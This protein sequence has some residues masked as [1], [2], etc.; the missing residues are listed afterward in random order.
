MDYIQLF[1]DGERLTLNPLNYVATFAIPA[2][3]LALLVAHPKVP[4][5]IKQLVAIPLLIANIIYPVLFTSEPILDIIGSA[6]NFTVN[7][8]FLEIVYIG[9]WLQDRPV[10]TSIYSLWVDFWSCIRVFP[11]PAKETT[12]DV[13]KGEIKVYTKDKKFYHILPPL[14]LCTVTM[15]IM[16]A[17]LGSFT[18]QDIMALRQEQPVFYSIFFLLAGLFM[19]AAFNAAGYGLHLFYCIFVEGGSYSSE[20]YHI[21]MNHPL[22]AS[23]LDD[24]WSH[25]WHQLFKTTWLAFP[26][27]P[28]RLVTQRLLAKHT[29]NYV[30]IS[31]FLAMISVFAISGLMHEYMILCNVGWPVFHNIFAGHQIIFFTIHGI[32]TVFER[33]VQT[34]AK[35]VLPSS[36]Y[37]SVAVRVL[38]H[39]WVLTFGAAFF[40]YFMEGFAHWGIHSTQP[41]QFTRPMVYDFVKSHP[42]IQQWFGSNY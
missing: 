40:S 1:K 27:R 34:I 6:F 23:S 14:L 41:I 35:R 36:V 7:L 9:P 2:G 22:I 18:V 17:W 25:R 19:T 10:Y 39:V 28:V 32:G 21:L 30:G 29:K 13:K 37:H 5:V 42:S 8:R 24:V 26:F 4:G 15:D 3:A 31:I 12:K 33:M 16:G 38:Q 20:Q 11:K